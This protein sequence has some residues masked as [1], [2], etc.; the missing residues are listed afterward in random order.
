[1]TEPKP[2]QNETPPPRRRIWPRILL[3][4]SLALN[5]AVA[6]VVGGAMLKF[7]HGDD[8]PRMISR[9]LGLAPF[10]FAFDPAEQEQLDAMVQA[11]SSELG[12]GRTE[13]R[14]TYFD[15][16]NAIRADPFDLAGFR[17]AMEDQAELSLKTRQVG[18][19]IMAAQ[20]ETMTLEQRR[21]FVERFVD[22]AEKFRGDGPGA[23]PP[24]HGPGGP[25]RPRGNAP[26]PPMDP[27]Q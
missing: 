23:H 20:F 15:A 24:H 11:R 7:A 5:L 17:A 10:R 16:L 14:K 8:H 2:P 21:A 6:G 26:P 9:E 19:D 22:R 18:L 13:W 1:M 12:I 4:V 3:F 25:G 27:G